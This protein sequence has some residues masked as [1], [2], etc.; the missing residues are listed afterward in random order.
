MILIGSARAGRHRRK[1]RVKL[2]AR[3]MRV[4]SGSE[5]PAFEYINRPHLRSVLS[6]SNQNE[7]SYI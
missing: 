3:E 7:L 5:W 4:R 6:E 2:V 1:P